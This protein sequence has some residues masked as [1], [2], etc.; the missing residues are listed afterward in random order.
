MTEPKAAVRLNLFI[1]LLVAALCTS[2]CGPRPAQSVCRRR[3]ALALLVC[4]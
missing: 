2:W 1:F 3:L 4:A